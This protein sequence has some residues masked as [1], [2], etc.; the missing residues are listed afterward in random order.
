MKTNQVMKRQMGMF[1]VYQRT[2][3]GYFNATDLLKQMEESPIDI[4]EEYKKEEICGA[5]YDYTD[6]G[7]FIP[8]HVLVHLMSIIRPDLFLDAHLLCM[9]DDYISKISLNNEDNV[10]ERCFKNFGHNKE[11]ISIYTYIMTDD[12]GLYKIGRSSNIKGRLKQLSI[13]NSSLKLLF[14]IEGDYE[15]ELHDKFANKHVKGE[16]YNLN[17]SDLKWIDKYQPKVLRNDKNN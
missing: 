15:K 2:N 4:I 11:N 12:T 1:A 6:N 13:G 5:C 9:S 10:F 14:Y 17:K 16:W 7:I 8:Y 3:D